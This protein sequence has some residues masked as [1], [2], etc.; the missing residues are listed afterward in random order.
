MQYMRTAKAIIEVASQGAFFAQAERQLEASE[1]TGVES[2]YRLS[3][4][5]ARALYTDITPARQDLIIL[6]RDLGASSVNA[7]AK[8]AGRNYS[9]THGD[10]AKL[11]ELGLVERTED[12]RVFVPFDEIDIR[13]LA[14]A[15]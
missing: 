15:A 11:V 9:N 14:L 10:V 12:G 6:L 7:L 4:Q 13:V 5:S 3:Y 8:A 2:D 1:R